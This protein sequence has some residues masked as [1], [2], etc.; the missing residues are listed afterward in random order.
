MK[1]AAFEERYLAEIDRFEKWLD[2]GQKTWRSKRG[3]DA[4]ALATGDVPATYRHICQLMALAR[5]R[6]YS[7]DLVDRLN[8][9]VL[10]GH[11]VLYGPGGGKRAQLFSF[12]ANGF[13]GAVRAESKSV[14]VSALLFFLPLLLLV[15]VLQFYPDFVHY[16]ASPAQLSQYEEMYNP[17]N[18]R[19]GQ[20]DSDDNLA[21][22]AF[23]IWNNVKI[24]IQTFATGLV[25]GLGTIFFLVMNGSIIGA[26]AGHLTAVGYGEPFWSFVSGHSAMELSA[27]VLSGAAGLILGA[28]VVA[29]GNRSRKMALVEAAKPAIRIMYGAALMFI[30]AAFIEG[31]WSPLKIFDPA[32]KY[33][34]GL[35][36]WVLVLAYFHLGGRPHG[37]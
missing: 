20:R 37:T 15:S 27:I 16:F 2:L 26:V 5:D 4:T 9:L 25:F 33:A 14:L 17:A 7:P 6:H 11:H 12:L 22:F 32:I 1:Q 31:F 8:H 13:P 28:A 3:D 34:F 36:Q 18:A 10:R 30:V 29:P 24:G 21:M 35:V 19:L 23:Y